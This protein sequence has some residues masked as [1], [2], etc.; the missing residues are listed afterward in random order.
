M[1]IEFFV[2]NL[3]LYSFCLKHFSIQSIILEAFSPKKNILWNIKRIS[4]CND[5][6]VEP[7]SSIKAIFDIIGTSDTVHP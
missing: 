7:R 2:G 1:P 4:C 5:E 3:I 6:S